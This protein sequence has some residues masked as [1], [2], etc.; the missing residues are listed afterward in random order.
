MLA[1][2]KLQSHD[3]LNRQHGQTTRPLAAKSAQMLSR[4][5]WF[6]V[7]YIFMTLILHKCH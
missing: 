1:I 4:G 5:R 6:A 2:R 7:H 3:F